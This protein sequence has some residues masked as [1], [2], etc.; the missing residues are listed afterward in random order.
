[1]NLIRFFILSSFFPSL[2]VV[3]ALFML[4]AEDLETNLV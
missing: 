2:H 1:M 4:T 3:A